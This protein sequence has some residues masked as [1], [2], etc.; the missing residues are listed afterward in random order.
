MPDISING[1]L[2]KVSGMTKTGY[3]AVGCGVVVFE[4]CGVCST[5]EGGGG[6][7]GILIVDGSGGDGNVGA[8]PLTPTGATSAIGLVSAMID[9]T[10][11]E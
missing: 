8:V 2:G 6:G 3:T 5:G 4:D 1:G 11:G 10:D 9:C 7:E